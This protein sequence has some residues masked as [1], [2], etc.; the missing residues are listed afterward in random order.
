[1]LYPRLFILLL[2]KIFL[3]ILRFL[4]S[5][6]NALCLVYFKHS[7]TNLFRSQFP[8]EKLWKQTTTY[9]DDVKLCSRAHSCMYYFLPK[10]TCKH[11]RFSSCTAQLMIFLVWTEYHTF[12]DTFPRDPKEKSFRNNILK[13]Q[14]SVV[15]LKKNNYALF[16]GIATTWACTHS[17]LLFA[18]FR[19]ADQI[20]IKAQAPLSMK[21]FV[22][23]SYVY[24]T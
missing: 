12:V 1:M 5:A 24:L 21:H 17:T 2:Q 15:A 13:L 10:F 7:C 22:H 3:V 14:Y 18:I 20:R 11:V 16:L 23:I 19:H 4:R 8:R 9:I 6:P